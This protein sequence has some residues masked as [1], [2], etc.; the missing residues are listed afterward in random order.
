MKAFMIQEN[1]SLK[2]DM[3]KLLDG[4]ASMQSL[5]NNLL[6]ENKSKDI[7]IKRLSDRV[8]D[9][10]QYTRRDDIIVSGLTTTPTSYANAVNRNTA[11]SGDATPPSVQESIE[12]QV[13]KYF[14]SKNIH[15]DPN[16][17][18]ACHTLRSK[19]QSKPPLIVMR[20]VNRKTKARILS[21]AKILRT[22]KQ[23][24]RG[25]GEET[26]A[27]VYV[28]EHLTKRNAQIASRARLL[29]KQRKLIG[30]WTRNGTVFVKFIDSGK[31]TKVISVKDINYLSQFENGQ[32]ST[33]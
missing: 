2:D 27:R 9:L 21:E 32:Y 31:A 15:V 19:D 17:V 6:K 11:E 23:R 13:L 5:I 8:D 12:S 16:E 26:E 4:Q 7:E 1:N 24:T 20:F 10:E 29:T 14:S 28:N 18:S 22:S 25:Q 3:R 30:T 33:T